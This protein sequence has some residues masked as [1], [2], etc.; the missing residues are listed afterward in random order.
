M[1]GRGLGWFSPNSTRDV[2]ADASAVLR[3]VASL[4]RRHD[5]HMPC[6][7]QLLTHA[8]RLASARIRRRSARYRC[9]MLLVVYAS[10]YRLEISRDLRCVS[11]AEQQ[12]V[13]D[14]GDAD[15]RAARHRKC[16]KTAGRK[17][18]YR[19]HQRPIPLSLR[20]RATGYLAEPIWTQGGGGERELQ[21]RPNR[22]PFSESIG[23]R[24][25]RFQGT[26]SGGNMQLYWHTSRAEIGAACQ[27]VP[28]NRV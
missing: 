25:G 18:R 21:G 8:G 1:E 9:G 28:E 12:A 23:T 6:A 14:D 7:V 16:R 13:V 17:I 5:S 22:A 19:L 2:L 27:D 3:R 15:A 11:I 20:I 10:A 24:G 4:W 26:G